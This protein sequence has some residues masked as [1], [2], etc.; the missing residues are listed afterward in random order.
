MGTE[1]RILFAEDSVTDV[2]LC[3]RSIRE[4]GLA[5]THLRADT[6]GDFSDALTDEDWDIVLSDYCMPQF[7][8][9]A[10]LRILREHTD[11]IPFIV[12]TGTIDE[13]TAVDCLKL[14]AD[15]Y[16]LKENL[17]RLGPAA[18][19]ALQAFDDR[20]ARRRLECQVRQAQK[21]EAV[22]ALAAGLAHS[23]CNLTAAILGYVEIAE[24]HVIGESPV[25]TALREIKE[26][27]HQANGITRS[28]LT[29]SRHAEKERKVLCLSDLVLDTLRWIERMLPTRIKI[30]A[31]VPLDRGAWING[32]A[33]QLRQILVNLATNSRDAISGEGSVHI[34]VSRR[35]SGL[36]GHDSV[37]E[38]GVAVIVVE[39]NGRGI[40]EDVRARIFEP[41]Y[42]T[43]D[44]EQGTGLGMSV[45]HG[46]VRDHGGSINVDSTVGKGT[47]VTVELPCCAGPPE[48]TAIESAPEASTGE[49]GMI[50]LVEASR[51]VRAVIAAGLSS[52]GHRVL[53]VGDGTKL[54]QCLEEHGTELT[55]CL[56]EHGTELDLL[57]VDRQSAGKA[58][59]TS[60][61]KALR[62]RA[63]L[64]LI[65]LGADTEH[66]PDDLVAPD[67]T[68]LRKP[69]AMTQLLAAVDRV[70]T[71][72]RSHGASA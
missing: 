40:P 70:P 33:S 24:K 29:F 16:I 35:P 39:D 46:I 67:V 41:F 28:L 54:T 48:E 36:L 71:R 9:M 23:F 34:S 25:S 6:A 30:R 31:D 38:Q 63:R 22:G 13:E 27:A 5:P 69:C 59:S 64:P 45:I 57:I 17:T 1:L 10:A 15:N 56:E 12:V 53:Q 37:I 4:F 61:A 21:M 14:G 66:K 20:R 50:L 19:R 68:V 58:G 72:S 47:V 8:A 18:E 26:I 42:T 2:E 3:L 7:D 60:L 44:R 55:Q 43:K 11:E 65:L 32:D 49:R 51:Q 52:A 62:A